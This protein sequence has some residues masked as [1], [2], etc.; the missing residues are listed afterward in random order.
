MAKMITMTRIASSFTC[1]YPYVFKVP[2]EQGL[3]DH[4]GHRIWL[5]QYSGQYLI[6]W[7]IINNAKGTYIG[8]SNETMAMAF[9]LRWL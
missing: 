4:Y 6:D 8:F 5:E 7:D 2:A 1:L 9:K 3:R